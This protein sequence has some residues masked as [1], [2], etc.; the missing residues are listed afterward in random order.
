[1]EVV[2]AS[3]P[4]DAGI[5]CWDLHSGAE[6]LRYRSC[7]STPHGLACVGQRFLASSQLRDSSSSSGSI[8]Y[9]SWSKPQV[10]V[11]SF[12]AE[13][14]HPLVSNSDGMYIIG[15]G[16]SGAIYFWEVASGRLLKRW[17]AHYRAVTCLFLSDDESLLVSGAEDGCIRV[18]SLFMVFDDIG[19]EMA[20]NPY[21]YSFSEHTLRVTDMVSGYGGCNA[22]IV[23]ASEDRTCKVWSLSRGKL[24]RSI[25]FPSIIEAVALDPGEHVFYAGARDGKIYIASINAETT[26]SNSYGKH[27][28]GTLSDNSKGVT[29]LAFSKDGILLVSGS[30]DGTIRVWDAKTH[31]IVRIYRLA[32][33]PVNN[34]LVVRRPLYSNRQTSENS[35]SSFSRR[36]APLLPPPLGKYVNST[37]ENVD[38]GAVSVPQ[39]PSSDIMDAPYLS[40]HVLTKQISELQQQSSAATGME[41]D[42]LNLDCKRSVEI[43]QKWKEMFAYLHKFCVDELLGNDQTQTQ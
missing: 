40:Y 14:I 25:D 42:R 17:H 12:P 30:E 15:G 9:W 23:S 41:V 34:V 38:S 29:C 5:G 24:L 10:E 3:S 32:K 27:I 21:E 13:P 37:D 20:K 26:S 43:V 11:K 39:T 16:S 28:I 31:N 6:Q 35:H 36:H 18:W 1:M 2:I 33:G 4:V 7:T 22:I 8:L 19:M